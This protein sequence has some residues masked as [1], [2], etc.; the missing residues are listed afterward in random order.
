MGGEWVGWYAKSF[1]RLTQPPESS[2]QGL[3]LNRVKGVQSI[4]RPCF[5]LFKG[6]VSVG[7]KTLSEHPVPSGF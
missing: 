7:S 3:S 4:F 6:L 1:S 2:S 5:A